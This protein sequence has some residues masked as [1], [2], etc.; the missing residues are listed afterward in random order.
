MKY[1]QVHYFTNLV[2]PAAGTR[3]MV[4]RVCKRLHDWSRAVGL[5]VSK[6]SLT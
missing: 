2:K 1:E 3:G 5:E 4:I 6:A